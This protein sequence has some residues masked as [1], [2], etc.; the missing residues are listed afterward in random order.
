MSNPHW[1]CFEAGTL[2][3]T[4]N[5]SCPIENLKSGDRVFAY[6]FDRKSVVESR[7]L[8]CHTHEVND[9]DQPLI[10]RCKPLWLS[11]SG[12]SPSCSFV[13]KLWL[14]QVNGSMI[15]GQWVIAPTMATSS[16]FNRAVKRKSPVTTWIW[17]LLVKWV[18]LLVANN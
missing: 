3:S 14:F 12:A 18:W 1:R 5:G 8:A 13:T 16:G 9:V 11:P 17:N 10:L 2:V 15:V 4:P 6:N 7:V